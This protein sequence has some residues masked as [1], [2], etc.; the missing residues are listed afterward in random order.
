MKAVRFSVKSFLLGVAALAAGLGALE[1]NSELVASLVFSLNL[2]LLCFALVGAI[3]A[4]GQTRVFWIGFVVFG[5]LYSLVAFGFLFPQQPTYGNVWFGYAGINQRPQLI[6]S[7]LLD[8]YGSLRAP[9]SIGEKVSAL[10]SGGGYYPA[11]ITNYK[12]GLYEVKWDDGSRPEWVSIGQMQPMGREL[13]RVG[14]SLF[15]LLLGF[16]GG[17]IA[18]CCL[19]PRSTKEKP[20][21]CP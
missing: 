17:L 14:H 19:S 2:L 10:W 21:A 6:T 18:V 9:R 8:L 12:E 20:A 1:S 4:A 16:L 15:A 5:G 7:R 11:T 13:E 3:V